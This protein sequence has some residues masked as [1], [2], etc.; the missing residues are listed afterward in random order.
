MPDKKDIIEKSLSTN[1]EKGHKKGIFNKLIEEGRKEA[2]SYT[3]PRTWRKLKRIGQEL[4]KMS[5]ADYA[6]GLTRPFSSRKEAA[7]FAFFWFVVP[8]GAFTIYLP[9]SMAKAAQETAINR[10]RKQKNRP[11][12]RRK[13]KNAAKAK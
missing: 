8:T 2:V 1:L 3:N 6:R 12:L 13:P 11:P 4:G 9:L 10:K 5:P 7:A